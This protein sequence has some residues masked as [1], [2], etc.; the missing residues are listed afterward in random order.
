M[1]AD[2]IGHRAVDGV[3]RGDFFIFTHPH[4]RIAAQQRWEEMNEAFAA[5][6]PYVAGSDKYDVNAVVQRVMHAQ[7]E[8]ER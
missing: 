2:E 1:K 5:Q 8:S 4:S 3:E 7:G 6:A